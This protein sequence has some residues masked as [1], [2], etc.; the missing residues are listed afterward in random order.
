LS[1]L[2]GLTRHA[3]DAWEVPRDLLLRRYPP[4]VTGGAL[5]RGHVPVFCFHSLEPASFERKLAHLARNGYATLSG[6]EYF[7]LILGTL[8]PPERAVVLTFDDGRSSVRTIG[9]PLMRRYGMKGLVFIVPG[10]TVSRPGRL[11]ATLD[12]VRSGETSL[13]ALLARESSEEAFLSWEE[14][15]DLA[16]TGLFE[17]HS[18][19]LSHARVHT[20]PQLE[21]FMHPALRRGYGPLD[22]PLVHSDGGDLPPAEIPLGTPLFRSLPRLSEATRFYEEP[23]VRRACVETVAREGGPLF[24]ER[25][26]WARRLRRSFGRSQVTGRLE[27]PEQ[28]QAAIRSELFDSRRQIEE[29]LGRES[30]HVCWPWHAAGPTARRIARE[31]CY[32][33]AY[34]GKVEGVPI[35]L[36][37][38]DPQADARIGEDY[39]ELLPGRG[40][41][42]LTAILRAKLSRRLAA[43][44]A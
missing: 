30:F 38:G 3:A 44:R 15:A 21:T 7:R 10:R 1:R 16:A 32:R 6:D 19:S 2:A 35:T 14:I 39:V 23:R 26:G 20:G 28:R 29:R 33:M 18:H 13:Q 9:L 36:P 22:L 42:S 25:P 34:G 4:F 27:T 11:P 24:F 41:G 43:A 12:D 40:R 31:A 17:F 8:A 37:G 5:P